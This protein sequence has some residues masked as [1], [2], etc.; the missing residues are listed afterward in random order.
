MSSRCVA[1]QHVAIFS[2]A[3]A[4]EDAGCSTAKSDDNSNR[5]HRARRAFMKVARD[6][7]DVLTTAT[8]RTLDSHAPQRA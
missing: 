5:S 7:A 1:P 3:G 6:A 4:P 8:T 2:D